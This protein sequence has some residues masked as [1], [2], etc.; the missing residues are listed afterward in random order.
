MSEWNN[1]E[2]NQLKKRHK[3]KSKICFR[4]WNELAIPISNFGLWSLGSK[5]TVLSCLRSVTIHDT[6]LD[7]MLHSLQDVFIDLLILEERWLYKDE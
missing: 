6:G 5:I 7:S 1:Q 3:K 4:R 2:C